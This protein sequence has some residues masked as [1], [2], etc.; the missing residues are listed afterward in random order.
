MQLP[1]ALFEPSLLPIEDEDEEDF[2]VDQVP[3]P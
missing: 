2:V 3:C 1:Q